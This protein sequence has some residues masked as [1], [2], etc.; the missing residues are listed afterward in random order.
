[1]GENAVYGRMGDVGVWIGGGFEKIHSTVNSTRVTAM[2]FVDSVYKLYKNL[3]ANN[4]Q[5]VEAPHMVAGNFYLLKFYD[6]A[7]NIIDVIGNK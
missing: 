1:M 2:F 6:P 5:I 7:G 4:I 3:K